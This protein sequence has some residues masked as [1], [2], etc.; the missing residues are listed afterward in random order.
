MMP[1]TIKVTVL[2]PLMM[3]GEPVAA[4]TVLALTPQDAAAAVG[5]GRAELQDQADRA[6]LDSAIVS[7]RDKLLASLGR[8][9]RDVLRFGRAA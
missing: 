6:A 1:A 4:G 8:G 3:H 2:R 7:D 9:P 5:S